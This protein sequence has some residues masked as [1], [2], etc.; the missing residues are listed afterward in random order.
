MTD[1]FSVSHMV[2]EEDWLFRPVFRGLIKGESLIDGTVDLHYIALL[3]EGIDV[4]QDNQFK[5]EQW[6]NRQHV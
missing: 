4:E 1:S 6:R 5:A 2:E 3:N